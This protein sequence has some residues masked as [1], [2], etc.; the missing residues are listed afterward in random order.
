MVINEK[1][2]MA[3]SKNDIST[4]GIWNLSFETYLIFGI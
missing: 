4:V 1:Y 3:N 2:Q